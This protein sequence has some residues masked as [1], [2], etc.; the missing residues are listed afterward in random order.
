ML[1]LGGFS[2]LL[3]TVID[4][5][6][7]KIGFFDSS[8]DGQET[9]LYEFEELSV[10]LIA[11]GFVF[12]FLSMV[13]ISI[14]WLQLA[15]SVQ[16]YIFKKD[17]Y[18]R[19]GLRLTRCVQISFV[20]FFV[21]AIVCMV[22]R[23]FRVLLILSNTLILLGFP[24]LIIGRQR[25]LNAVRRVL[26]P[27]DNH[28]Q[29]TRHLINFS[30]SISIVTSGLSSAFTFAHVLS[31]EAADMNVVPGNINYS[32]LC[33]QLVYFTALAKLSGDFWYLKLMLKRVR[34]MYKVDYE[35]THAVKEKSIAQ[36]VSR[37]SKKPS[38]VNGISI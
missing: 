27:G 10:N 12:L 22:L 29:Q 31:F 15:D 3:P 25:L 24:L 4:P 6:F 11:V 7:V 32:M 26:K 37:R 2:V 13:Q 8:E 1:F 20:F 38:S 23:L 34:L 18:A 35:R 30:T 33:Q 36:E 16:Q 14:T 19:L 28:L 9:V 21:V 5:T 17:S